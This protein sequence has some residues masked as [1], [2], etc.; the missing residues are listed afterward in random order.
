MAQEA[1]SEET[2]HFMRREW[3]AWQATNVEMEKLGLDWDKADGL[4]KAVVEWAEEL[5]Y[6]RMSQG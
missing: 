1:T 4:H 6:L 3:E 5:A 2:L